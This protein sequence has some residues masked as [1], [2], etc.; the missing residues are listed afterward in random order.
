MFV[1]VINLCIAIV[2]GVMLMQAKHA[3]IKRGTNS[4]TKF[5]RDVH[6]NMRY[7]Q[8][9][10][11]SA[12]AT[13]GCL[14][15]SLLTNKYKFVACLPTALVCILCFI[16]MHQSNKDEQRVRST[17]VVTKGAL[18]LGAAD[19]GT[20]GGSS[21]M[22]AGAALGAAVGGPAGMA[23]GAALG[24]GYGAVSG[25]VGGLASKKMTDVEDLG[26]LTESEQGTIKLP[27]EFKDP[28]LFMKRAQALGMVKDGD[29]ATDVAS[30][31]ISCA[32][33][34]SLEHLPKDATLE[35]KATLLLEG[36]V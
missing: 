7:N 33:K 19:N 25:A 34:A 23:A 10:F 36:K 26:L 4:V 9:V 15:L 6:S 17:R 1:L 31:I 12:V 22:M 35:E 20:L 24:Y 2:L 27:D 18:E 32:P 28:E 11:M 8:I 29:T 16:F 14:L 5:V 3:G 13:I 30:R 21:G